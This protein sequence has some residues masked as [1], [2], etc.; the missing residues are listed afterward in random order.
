MVQIKYG[1]S[2]ETVTD[3]FTQKVEEKNLNQNRDFKIYG[4]D[5]S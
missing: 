1:W 5:V 2:R 3:I 4:Q